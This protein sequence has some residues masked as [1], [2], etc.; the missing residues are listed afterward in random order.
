MNVRERLRE[1]R[2]LWGGLLIAFVSLLLDQF[3]KYLLL[4][5]FPQAQSEITVTPF[6]SIVR[7]WN[8]GI[9]F[10]MFAGHRQ[11]VILAGISAVIVLVLLVWLRRNRSRLVCVA[12]GLII[13]GASGNI[14]D[15][16][17]FGAV[18]DFLDFHIGNYHWPAFNIADSSIFIGVVLLCVH[19][20]LME[21]QPAKGQDQ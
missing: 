12:L 9:S 14:M 10:G 18:A 8:Y 6:F 15:R 2:L 3:S 16:I 19:S 4:A 5:H 1:G 7:V 21:T 17:R 20:M 13:G 11:P